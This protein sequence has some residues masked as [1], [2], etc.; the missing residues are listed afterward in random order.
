MD[1]SSDFKYLLSSKEPAER[2]L[3]LLTRMNSFE[4]E[5]KYKKGSANGDADALSRL[6]IEPDDDEDKEEDAPII[7]NNI[8]I[9]AQPLSLFA[10]MAFL[11]TS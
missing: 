6:S 8:I 5:I 7:I 3:R 2:L 1:R 10:G 9:D 4:Y 11:M